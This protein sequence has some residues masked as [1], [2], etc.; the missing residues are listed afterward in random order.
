[1]CV[2]YAGQDVM[3]YPCH[4]SMGNQHWLYDDEVFSFGFVQFVECRLTLHL[5][6]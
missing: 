5:V 2:D 1:M 4:G 6:I 3:I